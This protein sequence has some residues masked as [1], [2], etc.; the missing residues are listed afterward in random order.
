MS[1][2]FDS[3]IGAWDVIDQPTGAQAWHTAER[4]PS[5]RD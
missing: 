2:E 1:H 5:S 3:W 4:D